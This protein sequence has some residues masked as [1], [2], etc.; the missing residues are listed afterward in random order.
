MQQRKVK[1]HF[2]CAKARVSRR[3][4]KL[5]QHL[6][7]HHLPIQQCYKLPRSSRAQQKSQTNSGK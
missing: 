7:I 3:L 2:T 5:K 6:N 4:I 1:K